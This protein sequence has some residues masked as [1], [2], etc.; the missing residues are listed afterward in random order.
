MQAVVVEE[1]GGP[2]VLTLQERPAPEPGPG[3]VS[4]DVRF[5]S[6]NFT[7]VRNRIGDGLGR[8][9]FVPGVEVSGTVR[10]LG[11]GVEGLRIGQPVAALTRGSAHADVATALA[12]LTVELPEG[13]LDRPESG[14]ML[15][16]VPLAIMLLRRVAWLQP[17]ETALLHSAAGGVGTVAAQLATHFG[18]RPL[19]G[20][21]GS[22]DKIPFARRYGF[23]EVFTYDTFVDGVR[24]ATGGRGVDVVLDP[25]GG[26]VRSASFDLLAPF[27]RLVNY[28]NVS[29]EPEA[30]P[31]GEWM[32]AH[33]VAY[34]GYS[35]GQLSVYDP[36]L[37]RP[38]F[39]EA[40]GLVAD[41]VLDLG[42][43]GVFPLAEVAEA[44]RRF[45]DRSATGK[46]VL[47]VG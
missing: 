30:A 12:A 9:P 24:E 2:E 7:D 6:V 29:R 44:H 47:A 27:G 18:L 23:A 14:A 3:Q 16:A 17:D 20:T 41:G 10:Q 37:L 42:V 36:M 35:A 8:V 25:L 21:V 31:D 4:I 13:L 22:E 39:E 40:V 38:A 34:V 1:Y 26:A 43:T 45:A 5:A 32:R 28:S 19:L 11:E 33:C 46:L 15:V